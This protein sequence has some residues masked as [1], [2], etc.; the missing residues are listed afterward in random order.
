MSRIS[1]AAKPLLN[2]QPQLSSVSA[3]LSHAETN[4]LRPTSTAFIGTLYELHVRDELQRLL[5]IPH[6]DHY[7]GSYDNGRD[8][9]GTWDISRYIC[10][11]PEL[12]KPIRVRGRTVKPIAL[13]KS[14]KMD[15]LIQ[16]K[17]FSSKLTAKEI[18]ELSGI[19]NYNVRPKDKYTT[20]AIMSS[21]L[22]LTKQAME[23]MDRSEFPLMYV[24]IPPLRRRIEGNGVY[25]PQSY[26]GDALHGVYLNPLTCALWEGTQLLDISRRV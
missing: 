1:K 18:R 3:Y 12:I 9:G 26:V 20:L 25:D 7:G 22:N 14:H 21:P 19:F 23:Q 16:C 5:G 15:L 17:C 8:L 10:T 24:Q 2:S 6:L 11:P 13:R 4:S